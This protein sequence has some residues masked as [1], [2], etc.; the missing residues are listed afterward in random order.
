MCERCHEHE[1]DWK[2]LENKRFGDYAAFTLETLPKLMIQPGTDTTPVQQQQ[3][4]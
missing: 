2:Y 3:M 1:F 4:C